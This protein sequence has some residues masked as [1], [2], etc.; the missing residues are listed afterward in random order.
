MNETFPGKGLNTSKKLRTT[1]GPDRM[2]KA[3]SKMLTDFIDFKNFFRLAFK[4][5]LDIVE[6]DVLMFFKNDHSRAVKYED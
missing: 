2:N 3:R 4:I 6:F 5:V 1:I